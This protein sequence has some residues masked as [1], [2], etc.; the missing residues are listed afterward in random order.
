MIWA[1]LALA[2][3][4]G[5]VA[6]AA[7]VARSASHRAARAGRHKTTSGRLEP[8]RPG[9][10]ISQAPV[11]GV[12]LLIRFREPGGALVETVIAPKSIVG[13]RVKHGS[14]R[15]EVINA[16]CHSQHAMRAFRYDDIVWAADAWSGDLIDDLYNYLGGA[17][18]GGA[19][20]LPY[21]AERKV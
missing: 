21:A 5:L 20:A 18:P 9:T 8:A 3:G 14:V 7:F 15:P 19:P 17:Q 13:P 10:P 1:R 2:A 11:Y 16:F 4:A 6:G 12:D